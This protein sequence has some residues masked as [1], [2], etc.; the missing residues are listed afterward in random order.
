M[1]RPTIS[2]KLTNKHQSKFEKAIRIEAENRLRGNSFDDTVPEEFDPAETRAYIWLCEVLKPA[3]ILGEPDRETM[4][5]TAITIA[6]LERLD[7]MIREKP[8]LLFQKDYCRIRNGYITQYFH[9]CKELCLSP[10]AR[11]KIGSLAKKQKKEDPLITVLKE[12]E[13]QENNV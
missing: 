4:K 6:R 7:Q 5:L 11:S 1:A 3:D 2:A 12:A 10:G 8:A 9:F 13:A